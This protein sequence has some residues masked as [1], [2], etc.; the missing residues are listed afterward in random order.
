MRRV[1]ALVDIE[2][3]EDGSIAVTLRHP[4]HAG[5][6]LKFKVTAGQSLVNR[7]VTGV[8]DEECADADAF[9]EAQGMSD[10]QAFGKNTWKPSR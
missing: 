5:Q 1:K 3:L 9:F 10:A 7:A 6:W 8:Y 2:Q 4:K